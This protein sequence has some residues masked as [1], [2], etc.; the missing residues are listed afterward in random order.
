[1]NL[2]VLGSTKAVLAQP[3]Y[4]LGYSLGWE[5]GGIKLLWATHQ[6]QWFCAMIRAVVSWQ[7][8]KAAEFTGHRLRLPKNI[9][10]K[11]QDNAYVWGQSLL[12]FQKPDELVSERAGCPGQLFTPPPLLVKAQYIML[13]TFKKLPVMKHEWNYA[14]FACNYDCLLVADPH[15]SWYLCIQSIHGSGGAHTR[16]AC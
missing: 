13:K 15:L 6:K 11:E 5:G 1:M 2:C 14:N 16:E 7:G 12:E 9:S 3:S 10:F 4:Y 8:R